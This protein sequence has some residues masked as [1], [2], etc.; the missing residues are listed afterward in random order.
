MDSKVAELVQ[1][2]PVTRG[3]SVDLTKSN[4]PVIKPPSSV[5]LVVTFHVNFILAVADV[6]TSSLA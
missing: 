1:Y 4:P 3:T 6:V 5:M 2:S